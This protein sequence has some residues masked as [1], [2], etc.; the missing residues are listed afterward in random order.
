MARA[1]ATGSPTEVSALTSQTVRVVADPASRLFQA[2]VSALPVRVRDAAT[3]GWRPVSTKLAVRPDG[4]VAPEATPVPM[5]FSGGGAGELARVND[6]Q[7]RQVRLSWSG[8]VLPAPVLSGSTATYRDVPVA[9]ADLVI[10]AGAL[11]FRELLVVRTRAAALHPAV[12]TLRFGMTGTGLTVSRSPDGGLQA[13]DRTGQP[14]FT[15]PPARMWDSPGAKAAG[16]VVAAHHEELDGSRSADV[17]TELSGGVLTVRPDA[18]LLSDPD[19]AYPIVIDPAMSRTHE[20]TY[21]TMVWSNGYKFPN[22]S[23]E[24][25]R[26]GYDGWSSAPKKTRSFF[27]FDASV[28]AGKHIFSAV[29][30]HKQ[31]HSPNWS[32]TATSFG[33][34]VQVYRTGSISSSTSWSSQPSWADLLDDSAVVHGHE[35]VC[36]GYDRQEWNV[37][38]GV[39][40]AAARNYSTLTLG[41]KSADETDRDGWRKYDNDSSYPLITVRYNTKPYTPSNVKIADPS[42]SCVT[43]STS[44]AV[45]NDATPKF[46]ATLKD[47]DG[48]N[49]E[50][51][52]H[53]EVYDG[54]TLVWSFV[55]GSEYP[56][57]T[58][59]TAT[60]STLIN[61]KTYRWRVRVEEYVEESTDV[62][63][64]YPSS[65]YCYFKVDT[66]RP[67][68]PVVSSA[69]Y[70]KFDPDNVVFSGGVGLSGDFTLTA[71]VTDVT[72]YWYQLNDGPWKS[73][74]TTGGA[75]VTVP[76]VPDQFG[77]N[78][79]HVYTKDAAGNQSINNDYDFNVAR[80]SAPA[81]LWRFDEG[82]GTLAAD[83]SGNGRNATLGNGAAMSS[84]VGRASGSADFDG[85]DD[86]AQTASA[87]LDT[88]KSFTVS[89]WVRLTNN[90]TAVDRPILSQNGARAAGFHLYYST[91]F[92]NWTFRM[93]SSDTDAPAAA[94]VYGS[95]PVSKYVW[96]HLTGSYDAYNRQIRLFVNGQQVAERSFTTAWNAVGSLQFGRS[97]TAGA[98]AQSFAGRID[99]V[100]VWDR[101]VAKEELVD[102]IHVT[103]PATGAPQPMVAG[104]WKLDETTGTTGADVT[105]Y[106]K[107]LTVQ[108]GATWQADEDRGNV[109]RLN[110]NA[111]GYATTMGPITDSTG[112]FTISTWVKPTNTSNTGLI[113]AGPGAVENSYQLELSSDGYWAFSRNASDTVISCGTVSSST[114]AIVRS[115]DAAEFGAW[116]HLAAVYD[117][118]SARIFLYVNGLRQGDEDGQPFTSPFTTANAVRVGSGLND[119]ATHAAYSMEGLYDEI[120][121]YTGVMSQQDIYLLWATG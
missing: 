9:G 74:S 68:A 61:G 107:H 2:E 63:A 44:P 41:M 55:N 32:C 111:D 42:T 70:P 67:P 114:C 52:G 96:T 36:A 7:G 49:A 60:T 45:I 13:V 95:Q 27:R 28:F 58:T 113:I 112:S 31:I 17:A 20:R 1:V 73:Q 29:F 24:H 65:G 53:F 59:V 38:A 103:D 93:T 108:P 87:V 47:P 34:R 4:T 40:Y 37:E 80:G 21:W 18:R 78:V 121:V 94:S 84:T 82:S 72:S 76:I 99:H 91:T 77:I 33:P 35:D 5:A 39:E 102:V 12:R 75:V 115:D 69:T 106:L 79:L 71:A 119:G 8:G 117:A 90:G 89:A 62:S 48:A 11:G 14:V 46:Q 10:E 25:A 105:P 15:G 51:K 109:M 50:L 85:V 30:A 83:S 86:Y 110:G 98:W 56:S 118:P 19:A 54:S 66:T 57:G 97:K 23:T 92:Q 22:D 64:W 26:V 100:Y 101:V 16:H 88:T 81:G 120:S 104:H 43:S 3:N 116:T 6:E